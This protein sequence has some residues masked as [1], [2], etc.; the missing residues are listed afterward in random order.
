M[1]AYAYITNIIL[2]LGVR[3][4]SKTCN[5]CKL[6]LDNIILQKLLIIRIGIQ[7]LHLGYSVDFN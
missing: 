4:D 2:M 7:R 3:I 1:Y 5:Q 6:L